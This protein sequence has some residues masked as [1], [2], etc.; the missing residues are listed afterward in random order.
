MKSKK[1]GYW[2]EKVVSYCGAVGLG[3]FITASIEYGFNFDT[4]MGLCVSVCLM[5]SAGLA[6]AEERKEIEE[7]EN[8][9]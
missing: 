1:F 7:E 9:G 8:A 5:I 2:F 4:I 6:S 3:I